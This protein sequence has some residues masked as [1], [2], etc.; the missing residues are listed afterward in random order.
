MLLWLTTP[1]PTAYVERGF[2]FMT[3]MDSNTRRRMKESNF[4]VDFLVHLHRDWLRDKLR[5]VVA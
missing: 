3:M 2:S 5:T 1:I 4:L